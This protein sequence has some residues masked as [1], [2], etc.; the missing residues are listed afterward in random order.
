M[1]EARSTDLTEKQREAHR[2]FKEIRAGKEGG[3]VETAELAETMDCS[4]QYAS[5]LLGEL[6]DEGLVAKV[7]R[8]E[9]DLPENVED[10]DPGV[11]DNA[12]NEETE[13]YDTMSSNGQRR[14][15]FLSKADL[16]VVA[17]AEEQVPGEAD[18]Y[19]SVD[20]ELVKTVNDERRQAIVEVPGNSM[21]KTISG[22][23]RVVVEI[24][25][26]PEIMQ[27]GMY[28]W[29][30]AHRCVLSARVHFPDGS[31]VRLVPD[32]DDYPVIELEGDRDDWAWTCIARVTQVL[33]GV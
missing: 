22:N 15:P 18:E 5:D 20:S 21:S 3:I 6:S 13:P 33:S 28:L 25:Q 7:K 14:L 27:G 4:T 8:G 11:E 23:S 16:P 9:Y 1:K 32:N 26:E 17:E 12:V 24:E 31:T 10:D 19:L 2:A 29:V 30:S